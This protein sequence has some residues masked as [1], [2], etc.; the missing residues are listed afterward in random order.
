MGTM[1]LNAR[2]NMDLKGESDESSTPNSQHSSIHARSRF[3]SRLNPSHSLLA[4]SVLAGLHSDRIS[5]DLAYV[6]YGRRRRVVCAKANMR[7]RKKKA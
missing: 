5:L 3:R 6:A 2:P 1:V 4:S 7:T